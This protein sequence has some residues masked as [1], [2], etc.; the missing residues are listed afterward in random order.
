MNKKSLEIS[1]QINLKNNDIYKKELEIKTL[2]QEITQLKKKLFN[3]CEHEWE[4]DWDDRS[5]HSTWL[6]K[7]CKLYR[8]PNYN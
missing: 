1:N 2:K 6:C 5:C 7:H 3:T 4:R 8:N